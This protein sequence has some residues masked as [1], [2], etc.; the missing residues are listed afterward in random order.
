MNFG[1]LPV[2]DMLRIKKVGY[3]QWW[4]EQCV[5]CSDAELEKVAAELTSKYNF[6][7]GEVEGELK[8]RREA[9]CH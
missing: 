8:K 1:G 6:E 2:S 5:K 3:N 7:M 4:T 9:R